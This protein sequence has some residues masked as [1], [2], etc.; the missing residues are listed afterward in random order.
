MHKNAVATMLNSPSR[1]RGQPPAP[2]GAPRSE[3]QG[4]QTFGSDEMVRRVGW[5][6][7]ALL[8]VFWGLRVWTESTSVGWANPAALGFVLA[9]LILGVWVFASPQPPN[10]LTEGSIMVF[11]AAAVC[12]WGYLQVLRSPAYGTDAIA[13]DQ[14]AA[15]LFRS[16]IN[17]YTQSLLPS[18]QQFHV[19]PIYHT[20]LLDG[21]EVDGLSYP[22][23]SFLAYLP[24]LWLGLRAQAAVFTDL[25]FWAVAFLLLWR[26]LPRQVAWTASLTL[27][28]VTYANFVVG[29][30]TDAL[31]LPFV[32]LAL[33]RWDRYADLD[34]SVVARWL[35]PV[36][37]GLA[38]SVKQTTW[39]LVP[40]LLIAL[41][42]EARLHSTRAALMTPLRYLTTVL[43]V[44]AVINLPFAVWSPGAWLHGITL[45]LTSPFVPGGQG[46]INMSLFERLGGNLDDY[47]LVGTLA[48]ITALAAFALYYARLKRAWVPLVALIFFWPTRSFASYLIDLV[49][50]AI[51]AATTVRS[52]PAIASLSLSRQRVLLRRLVVAVPAVAFLAAL[53]VA[54]TAPQPLKLE[55]LEL[56]STG[57]LRTIDGIELRVHNRSDR[58]LTPHFTVANGGY[59]T[60]FWYPLGEAEAGRSIPA[61]SE[62]HGPT[63]AERPIDAIDRRRFRCRSIT[64]HPATVTPALPC[65]RPHGASPSPRTRSTIPS[66]SANG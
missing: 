43:A 20:Y 2:N 21:G 3:D 42:H 48:V 27:G 31:F 66:P 22:A 5:S 30:V 25:A 41:A 56:H 12:C 19:P 24:A 6:L 35:S 50:A 16:G 38:V 47:R 10:R 55:I 53:V 46:I 44:F 64:A 60:S 9:G 29:G 63:R 54:V 49:P 28:L 8:V 7:G 65:L 23:L 52:A 15:E 11:L 58:P 13:F 40:F 61:H 26:L 32:F 39:F 33:W 34:A 62:P 1:P 18:L 57:Q 4:G 45:P 37:L 36:A 14:Y 59:L 51:L 17:P